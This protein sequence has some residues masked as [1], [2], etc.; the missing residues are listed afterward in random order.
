ML[1]VSFICGVLVLVFAQKLGIPKAVL[2]AFIGAVA[3]TMTELFTPSE[4]DT[5]TVPVVIEAVLL[6]LNTLGGAG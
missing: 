4:F 5:V 1:G 2:L 3:G 6:I